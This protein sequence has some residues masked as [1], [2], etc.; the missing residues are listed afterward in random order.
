MDGR[1]KP[2]LCHSLLPPTRNPAFSLVYGCRRRVGA[3]AAQE[4]LQRLFGPMLAEHSLDGVVQLLRL[5]MGEGDHVA[6]LLQLPLAPRRVRR[7]ERL[8]ARD[9]YA[10]GV[11][12][13]VGE[14]GGVAP[15]LADAD[16][17]L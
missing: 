8:E 17:P 13:G 5:V 9:R 7:S 16:S 6:E 2:S 10:E 12:S 14:V 4:V 11:A 1:Q 15:I 3:D